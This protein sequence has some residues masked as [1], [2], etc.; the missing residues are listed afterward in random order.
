MS[1]IFARRAS[2]KA[3]ARAEAFPVLERSRRSHAD[4]GGGVCAGGPAGEAP[5]RLVGTILNRQPAA[6]CRG[7]T[8]A[9]PVGRHSTAHLY[10]ERS[11]QSVLGPGGT[12]DELI[13]SPRPA[14][15]A[16]TGQRPGRCR[17]RP[18][19]HTYARERKKEGDN[20]KGR[21]CRTRAGPA[22][23]DCGCQSKRKAE[24]RRGHAINGSFC[25]Q[26]N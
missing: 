22:G 11:P 8:R 17:G 6:Q 15:R 25:S 21:R 20:R 19:Q 12:P 16:A 4:R 10:T 13:T 7:E 5:A 24:N 1:P 2:Q 23:Q 26:C 3:H 9:T 18:V 14:R